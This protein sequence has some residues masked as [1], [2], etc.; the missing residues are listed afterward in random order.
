[1]NMLIF[2]FQNRINMHNSYAYQIS[3]LVALK[4]TCKSTTWCPKKTS[5]WTKFE[6]KWL[7]GELNLISIKKLCP[8]LTQVPC[9]NYIIHT[10]PPQPHKFNYCQPVFLQKSYALQSSYNFA[11][12]K[13]FLFKY[14]KF[15]IW[16]AT[17]LILHH[18][19]NSIQVFHLQVTF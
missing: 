8:I 2:Y 3:I 9:P 5:T 6:I 10:N 4:K 19:N 12:W 13:I 11:L 16:L 17:Q 14:F 18:N 15:K 1:M 7:V